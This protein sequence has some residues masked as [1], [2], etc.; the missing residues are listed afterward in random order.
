MNAI[1]K[2]QAAAE[3]IVQYLINHLSDNDKFAIFFRFNFGYNYRHKT[4]TYCIYKTNLHLAG[5]MLR[6]KILKR[7]FDICASAVALIIFSPVIAVVAVMVLLTMGRPIFFRQIRPGLNG[8]PFEI[9]KFRSM[10]NA[11]D[12]SGKPLSDAQRL[13]RFGDIMRSY[14]L[15][16][17]PQLINILKG[18]MSVVG[19]RPL[20]YDFFPYYTAKEMRRHEVKPGITGPAQINGRNNLNWD[21]RLEMDVD[22]VDNWSLWTDIKIILQTILVVLKRDGVKTD[23]YATFLRLDDYRRG[24]EENE[25]YVEPQIKKRYIQ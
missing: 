13:T 9:L 15:D 7:G 6:S 17:L 24:K 5:L 22:Y 8:K 10:K 14:S 16:E 2:L 3:I 11:T 4:P 1:A 18:D 25:V 21:D 23:G 19:P 12:S 20:L